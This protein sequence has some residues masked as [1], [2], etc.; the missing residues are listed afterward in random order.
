[1]AIVCKGV[2]SLVCHGAEVR[3]RLA[4]RHQAIAIVAIDY[5]TAQNRR[6]IALDH[7]AIFI[8]GDAVAD[9]TRGRVLG[10]INTKPRFLENIILQ[11]RT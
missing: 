8:L 5:I 7:N 3:T 10:D 2:V 1:M 9:D 6:C 4:D 11:L